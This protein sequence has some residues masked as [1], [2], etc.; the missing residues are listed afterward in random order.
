M[1]KDSEIQEV[2]Q[3]ETRG[4]NAEQPLQFLTHQPQPK[5]FNDRFPVLDLEN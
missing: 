1:F 2:I 5:S 3:Q 4:T